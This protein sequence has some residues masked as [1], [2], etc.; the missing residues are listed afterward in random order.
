MKKAR[1][2]ETCWFVEVC[3]EVSADENGDLDYDRCVYVT[4]R[5]ATRAAAVELA[6]RLFPQEKLGGVAYW[7]AEF[8]PYD[9]AD[10]ASHPHAG[11]WEATEDPTYYEEN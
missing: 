7:P 2:G 3:V 11:Y 6:R 4:H 5:V 9:E 10:A 1:V 8:V